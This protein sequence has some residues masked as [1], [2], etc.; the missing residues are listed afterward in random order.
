[1]NRLTSLFKKRGFSPLNLLASLFL[2]YPLATQAFA[3]PQTTEAQNHYMV[4]NSDG[5]ISTR[6]D[7]AIVSFGVQSKGYT[8]KE[9]ME[10]TNIIIKKI[11]Q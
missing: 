9:A 5:E 2:I 3:T 11:M 1:M 10:K 4:I 6:P 8:A 7:M